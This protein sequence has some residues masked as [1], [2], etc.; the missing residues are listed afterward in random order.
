[1]P[2]R[3]GSRQQAGRLNV[4]VEY[5]HI[6][7]RTLTL[8]FMTITRSGSSPPTLAL[9]LGDPKARSSAR[10]RARR[11]AAVGTLDGDDAACILDGRLGAC[12]LCDEP[13]DE[14]RIKTI[15]RRPR[16]PGTQG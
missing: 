16:A 5:G 10:V 8:S 4:G 3:R 12:V 14:P 11:C 15:E 9:R 2:Q 6:A 13:L 7:L 1:V